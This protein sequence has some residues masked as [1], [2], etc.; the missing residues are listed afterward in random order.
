MTQQGGGDVFL[1]HLKYGS[2]Y[3]GQSALH[4]KKTPIP[5]CWK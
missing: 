2:S 4:P 5:D 1:Y 3:H